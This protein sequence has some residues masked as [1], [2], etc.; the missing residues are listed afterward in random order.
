MIPLPPRWTTAPILFEDQE[1]T[2]PL[3]AGAAGAGAIGTAA[4]EQVLADHT[5]WAAIATGAAGTIAPVSNPSSATVTGSGELQ[6]DAAASINARIVLA[7]FGGSAWAASG[8]AF[9]RFSTIRR[10]DVFCTVGVIADRFCRIGFGDNIN[11]SADLGNES[12]FWEFGTGGSTDWS[13]SHQNAGVLTSITGP[14]VA[15]TKV[16]LTIE[17]IVPAIWSGYING[18]FVGTH[19]LA[20][21]D[22]GSD[23]R[24]GIMWGTGVANGSN[25]RVDRVRIWI[26]EKAL[27]I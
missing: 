10:L 21:S 14:A 23:A 15:T 16:K 1:F 18:V 2:G 11:D 25:L 9:L 24:F 22:S 17:Q 20:I 7:L 3:I 27:Y 19:N 6:L 12:I 4:F 26:D 8:T 5:G 13:F